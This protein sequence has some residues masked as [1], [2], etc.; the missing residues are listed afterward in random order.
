MSDLKERATAILKEFKGD[1]Y[2]FGSCVLDGAPG[3]ISA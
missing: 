2:A 1:R 3:K